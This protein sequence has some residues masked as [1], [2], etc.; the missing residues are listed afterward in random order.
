MLV[1]R[2]RNSLTHVAWTSCSDSTTSGPP[3]QCLHRRAPQLVHPRRTRSNRNRAGPFSFFRASLTEATV[4]EELQGFLLSE[5]SAYRRR[6][7]PSFPTGQ[8]CN[9]LLAL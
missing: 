6:R 2:N 3:V 4:S 7:S 8:I 9:P 5:R 1:R